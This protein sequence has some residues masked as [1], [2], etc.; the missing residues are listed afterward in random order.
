MF[1]NLIAV[2]LGKFNFR[3]SL[4]LFFDSLL[5]KL[6]KFNFKLSLRLGVLL[7]VFGWCH[8]CF[9][10]ATGAHASDAHVCESYGSKIILC[11]L[12]RLP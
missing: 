6:S 1:N 10:V 3:F 2:K 7:L 5:F 8:G 12:L 4:R 9:S 11:T